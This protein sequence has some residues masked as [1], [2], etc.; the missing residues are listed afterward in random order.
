VSV[1]IAEI[2]GDWTGVHPQLA[3]RKSRG[4]TLLAVIDHGILPK[5]ASYHY[6]ITRIGKETP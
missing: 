4:R 6:T 5:N 1:E 2:E 3:G